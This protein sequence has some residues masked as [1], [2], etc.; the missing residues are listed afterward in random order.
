MST[1]TT[2]NPYTSRQLD[3]G[4]LYCMT[5][6]FLSNKSIYKIGVTKDLDQ[7]LKAY[8]TS[9][10]NAAFVCTV[11]SHPQN[12]P[13]QPILYA[14][15]REQV[16]HLKL[17]KYRVSESHE[18]FEVDLSI[19]KA[20][21]DEVEKMD[22]RDLIGHITGIY[23]NRSLFD[24]QLLQLN[25]ELKKENERLKVEASEKFL[26]H[27][28]AILKRDLEA[29]T[30]QLNEL[31][32]K[33]SSTKEEPK[34]KEC[35][36]CC[37]MKE[38]LLKKTTECMKYS[39]KTSEVMKQLAAMQKQFEQQFKHQNEQ[40]NEKVQDNFKYKYVVNGSDLPSKDS[41]KKLVKDFLMS[42]DDVREV[43]CTVTSSQERRTIEVEM[44]CKFFQP[45]K[46]DFKKLLQ[47]IVS[48]VMSTF[49]FIGSKVEIQQMV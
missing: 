48:S 24:Q 20:V 12:T 21:F 28:C 44:R 47:A 15:F 37:L 4:Y 45:R 14:D 41:C 27:Q 26:N 25:D 30:K 10:I 18:F 36:N 43:H 29:I 40:Q 11:P 17:Q 39:D 34:V 35:E 19:I 16:V 22:D 33:G 13:S 1:T 46:E 7:R 38:E 8:H 9:H 42:I 49:K 3:G 6:L 31:K 32:M 2:Q 5:S 23:K